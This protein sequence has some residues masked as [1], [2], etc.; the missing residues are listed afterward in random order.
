MRGNLFRGLG[1]ESRESGGVHP[2]ESLVE[3]GGHEGM[4]GDAVGVGEEGLQ[5]GN[6]GAEFGTG[7]GGDVN[8]DGEGVGEA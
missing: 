3:V 5:F 8:G 4:G 7:L 2:K 6:G 1:K